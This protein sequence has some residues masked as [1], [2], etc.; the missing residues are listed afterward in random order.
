[1]QEE[2][3]VV[4]KHSMCQ[5]APTLNE[6][7]GGVYK[8]C[9]WL[10]WLST[11]NF[12]NIEDTERKM[13]PL[14][15][16]TLVLLATLTCVCCFKSSC[17]HGAITIINEYIYFD[18]PTMLRNGAVINVHCIVFHQLIHLGLIIYLYCNALKTR[19]RSNGTLK[20][21]CNTSPLNTAAST[22][23]TALWLV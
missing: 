15:A 23:P 12:F 14:H 19:W 10:N 20:M 1:M 5:S 6:I 4:A 9:I 21:M 11:I 8:Y 16:S 2:N 7:S 17:L 22:P 13:D 18:L 3:Q